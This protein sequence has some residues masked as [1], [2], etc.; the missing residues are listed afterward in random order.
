MKKGVRDFLEAANA[1][2]TTHDVAD[3]MELVGDDSVVFVDVRDRSEIEAHGMIPGAVHASRGMLEFHIDPAS[4]FHIDALASGNS[5]VF[6]CGSG[7]R[8]ALAARTAM[9]IGCKDVAHIGGGF[10]A[11]LE[12]GGPVEK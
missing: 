3:A 10:G 6:Y 7:G 4:P 1:M 8:S 11:W 9:E 2:V 12:A 5:L